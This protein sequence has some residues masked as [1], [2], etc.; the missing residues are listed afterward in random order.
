MMKKAVFASACVLLALTMVVRMSSSAT[1]DPWVDLDDSGDIDIFDVV[2]LA[3]SY[4]TAGDPTKNVT[5]ARRASTLAFSIASLYEAAGSGYY[6][7]WITVDGYAKVTVCLYDSGVGDNAYRL[8]TRHAGGPNVFYADT[9]ANFGND[10]V[11]TYD[12]PNQEVRIYYR[13]DGSAAR[14]IWLDV[15]LTP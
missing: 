12:V 6:S 7:P 11:R 9:A 14:Y 4:A 3:G 5:I 10:V 8:E 15:Y 1:Y 2:T 13:N